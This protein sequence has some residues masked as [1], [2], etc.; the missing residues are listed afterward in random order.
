MRPSIGKPIRSILSRMARSRIDVD[1]RLVA[2]VMERYH[3]TTRREAVEHA[4][5]NLAD[6]PMTK[7]EAL[8]MFGSMPDFDVPPA[9]FDHDW[10]GPAA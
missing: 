7:V 3:F 5:R 4:L 6:Q 8:A 9:R 2:A 10:T 1:D